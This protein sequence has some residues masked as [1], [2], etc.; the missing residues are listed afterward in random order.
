MSR[1]TTI[2]AVDAD[3]RNC[4]RPEIVRRDICK[5]GEVRSCIGDLL[6]AMLDDRISLQSQVGITYPKNSPRVIL[7]VGD[8]AVTHPSVY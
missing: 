1:V 8:A 7:V 5:L 6:D 3:V 4:N 2:N